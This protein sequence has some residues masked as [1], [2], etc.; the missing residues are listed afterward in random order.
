MQDGSVMELFIT[1][2]FILD[3]PVE[4]SCSLAFAAMDQK[5]KITIGLMLSASPPRRLVSFEQ[6]VTTFS[7]VSWQKTGSKLEF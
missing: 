5:I 1:P 4:E 7:Q 2:L 3:R 6:L